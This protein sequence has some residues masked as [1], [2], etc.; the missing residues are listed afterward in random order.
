MVVDNSWNLFGMKKGLFYS[1]YDN[2]RNSL[3]K[4]LVNHILSKS[5]GKID[6]IVVEAGSGPGQGSVFMSMKKR[7]KKAMA[8]DHD[9]RAFNS[10]T[11]ASSKFE[12]VIGDLTKLPFSDKSIDILWNSSTMEHLDTESFN[13]SIQEIYRVLKDDG[14]TFIGVPYKFGPLGFS[15]FTWESMK[16]WVGKLFSKK[17]LKRRLKNFKVVS[18][19]IYFFGF[20]VGVIAKKKIKEN[21]KADI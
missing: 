1:I 19:K 11:Y 8:M 18:S 17:D 15:A 6:L 4:R 12:K 21:G 2:T 9:P 7:V 14:Y 5:K 13:L 3:N 16:E 10:N 20:F